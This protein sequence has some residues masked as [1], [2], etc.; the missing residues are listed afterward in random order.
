[1]PYKDTYGPK[2]YPVCVNCG[3]LEHPANYRGCPAYLA[4]IRKQLRIEQQREMQER[5]QQNRLDQQRYL[6]QRRQM[7]SNF[8]V[9]NVSYAST[10][11]QNQQRPQE[12][13]HDE[14]QNTNPNSGNSLGFLQNEF[15]DI[16]GIGLTDMLKKIEA[17]TPSYKL[18]NRRDKQ[19]ALLDFVC[20]LNLEP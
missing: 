9:P 14:P 3:S 1:M 10:V 13:H 17:F 18:L 15:L 20:N 2:I 11:L 12:R 8:R 6:Q 19:F 7:H 5:R 16:F 4:L